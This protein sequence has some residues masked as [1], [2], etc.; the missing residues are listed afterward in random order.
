MDGESRFSL[1]PL[2]ARN[3]SAIAP[4]PPPVLKPPSFLKTSGP[5]SWSPNSNLPILARYSRLHERDGGAVKADEAAA[6]GD[7]GHRGG[8]LLLAEGLDGRHFL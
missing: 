3:P 8:S 1:S 4:F 7:V 2:D 6:G 5:Q